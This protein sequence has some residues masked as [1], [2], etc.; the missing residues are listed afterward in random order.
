MASI[1]NII[2]N[3]TKVITKIGSIECFV[4]GVVVRG[5]SN[6][7]VEYNVSW[8]LNGERKSEW[9]YDF[10]IE[11]KIDNSKPMGFTKSNQKLIN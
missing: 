4:I 3:G 5:K 8:F 2:P 7:Q 10:E 11:P 6:N 1:N 9:V